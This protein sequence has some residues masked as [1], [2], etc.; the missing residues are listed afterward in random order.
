M[1]N[2]LQQLTEKLYNEGLSRGKQEAEDLLEKSRMEAKKMIDEAQK[3]AD[4]IIADAKKSADELAK[5]TQTEI[6]L[7]SAQTI[8]AI[9][10]QIQNLITAQ[11]LNPK[12]EAANDDAGFVKD[13]I[14]A[15]AK[16]WSPDKNVDLEVML[17]DGAKQTFVDGVTEGIKGVLGTGVEVKVDAHQS[18]GFKI[19]TKDSSYYISFSNEDFE[20][21]LTD[22]LR[23]KVAAMLFGKELR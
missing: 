20:A 7:A 17:S 8:S 10:Q 6:A 5:N 21:L 4:K 9:K 13:V 11:A 23:P 2:K 18:S 12:V 16:G 15:I 22:Y 3:S 1:E 19:G 14:I